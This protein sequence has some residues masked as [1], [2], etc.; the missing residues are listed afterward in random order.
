MDGKGVKVD[1][2]GANMDTK[3]VEVEGEGP[4]GANLAGTRSA[5]TLSLLRL[6]GVPEV[7]GVPRI[8]GVPGVPGV[9]AGS[10]SLCPC[11]GL[12]RGFCWGGFKG[13]HSRPTGSNRMCPHVEPSSSIHERRHDSS[14]ASGSVLRP[15][16]S[17]WYTVV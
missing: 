1:G 11:A 9:P 10:G 3:G 4:L 17:D 12:V 15:S 14:V 5:R 13:Q 7:P 2:K 8:P 6:P 16:R